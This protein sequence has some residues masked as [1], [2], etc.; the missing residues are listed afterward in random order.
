MRI[1]IELN[2]PQVIALLT[3]LPEA[4]RS[5]YI[6][7]SILLSDTVMRY[8][9]VTASEANL[10]RYFE[11]SLN[12][13]NG[14]ITTLAQL[15]TT[16]QSVFATQHQTLEKVIPAMAASVTRGAITNEAV[17][18]ALC[19]SFRDDE[20][21]DVSGKTK[22]TDLCFTPAGCSNPIL[23]EL[24]DHTND[25]PS[26]EVEKFWRDMDV[27]KARVGVFISMN[28]RIQ[29][30]TNDFAIQMRGG[31]LGIFVVN[32]EFGHRGYVLAYAMARRL[33]LALEDRAQALS[34]DK[35]GFMTKVLNRHL[36]QIGEEMKV[37]G[38]LKDDLDKA[39]SDFNIKLSRI[40]GKMDVLRQRVQTIVEDTL[41]DF[42]DEFP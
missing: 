16:Y 6:E 2:D 36:H 15:H 32:R 42:S 18:Q 27:R 21:Q 7:R 33:L 23:I 13:L 39:Q 24:K 35:L 4:E 11:P 22:F 30:L 8:A 34:A 25:V 28:T 41:R 14:A 19:D 40:T 17:Y 1:T 12:G 9:Q 3:S 20:A 38:S 29:T 5:T 37:L 31:Q 10:Q 26:A